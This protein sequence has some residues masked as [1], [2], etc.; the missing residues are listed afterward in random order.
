M[1]VNVV[2]QGG[3]DEFTG[4]KW[5]GMS[6]VVRKVRDGLVLRTST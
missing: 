1:R 2:G 6:E 3:R 5:F 4:K